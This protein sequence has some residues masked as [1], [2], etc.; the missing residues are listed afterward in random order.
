MWTFVLRLYLAAYC[1]PTVYKDIWNHAVGVQQ[2]GGTS[3]MS[4]EVICSF[5]KRRSNA[6]LR[7][8][9]APP[10]NEQVETRVQA[11]IKVYPL[12]LP[13]MVD[14]LTLSS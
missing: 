10:Y 7:F 1:R 11:F 12:A 6:P 3:Y 4:S 14:M 2:A 9:D 8:T 13:A 5:L